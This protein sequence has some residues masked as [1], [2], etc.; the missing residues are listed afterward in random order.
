MRFRESVILG[1]IADS[2]VNAT[3]LTTLSDDLK[4]KHKRTNGA[5]HANPSHGRRGRGTEAVN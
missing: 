1:I 4:R 2:E 5:K 3:N